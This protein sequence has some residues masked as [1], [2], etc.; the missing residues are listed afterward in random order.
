M[1]DTIRSVLP[2]G[3]LRSAHETNYVYCIKMNE[4]IDSILTYWFGTCPSAREISEQKKS[5]WWGK[6]EQVD[7]E[8]SQRFRPV[9]ESV[10]NSELDH[11]RESANGLL[12]S[13]ICT[14]Q[15]PRNVFRGNAKSFAFDPVALVLA[16]Q[17]VAT[18]ADLE[19]TPI[20]RVFV[21]LPF[22]HSE[23]MAM[24]NQSLELFNKLHDEV[25]I[26]DK[27]LFSGY[28]DF[29]R[30]HLQIIKRFGRFP[31]RNE[32][33]GRDSTQEELEFLAEPGSSF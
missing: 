4:T 30:R 5:L 25:Q 10:A 29:A 32:V 26:E 33:L 16:Q 28:V 23:D 19:L 6:D 1:A 12:A 9:I 22:E 24:Q 14:D 15:F 20:H 31:H 2:S 17:A 7:Q 13:I 8:I 27:E 21:Y 18:H 3:P 11:W